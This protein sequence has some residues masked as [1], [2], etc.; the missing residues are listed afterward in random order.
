MSFLKKSMLT[1][2]VAGI[3]YGNIFSMNDG[4]DSILMRQMHEDIKA[5]SIAQEQADLAELVNWEM[6]NPA[7]FTFQIPGMLTYAKHYATIA[8]QKI[9]THATNFWSKLPNFN[10]VAQSVKDFGLFAKAKAVEKP[11]VAAGIAAG[12]ALA[13]G[14][15]IVMWKKLSKPKAQPVA[16]ERAPRFMVSLD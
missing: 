8:A 3:S 13:V 12:T 7:D 5:A 9:Q 11:Y 10:T 1:L 16:Q 4:I 2:L 6:S 14:V 15:S